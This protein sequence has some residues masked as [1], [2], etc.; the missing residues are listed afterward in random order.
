MNQTTRPTQFK[1]IP[2]VL[3]LAFDLGRKEWKL[4]FTVGRGERPRLRTVAAGDLGGLTQEIDRARQRWGVAPESRVVS[5]YEAGRDGFWLHRYLLSRGISN[6]VVDSSSIEVNRRAR[7][8]KT[9]RLDAQKLLRLL[10]RHDLGEEE[11]RVWSVV[12]VPSVEQEADRQLHRDWEELKQERTL[13][14]NRIQALLACQGITLR[15]GADFGDRLEGLALWDG[16]ALPLP[17]QERLKREWERLKL[18]EEQI[19]DLNREKEEAVASAADASLQQIQ[20]LTTL[21]GIGVTSAWLFV[22]E[23]FG[24]RQFRNRREVGALAGLA[25]VPCQSGSTDHEQGI[26]KAGNVRL[27]TM[28]IEI[29]WSWL[30][31]QPTSSL[32]LWFR[33]RYG[34]G[35]RRSRRVGIVALARKLLVSLWR[36]LETGV[37]PEGAQLKTA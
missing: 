17:L 27:R 34:P 29:A 35:S 32:S 14:R 10:V 20:Q 21:K 18:V 13:H 6:L 15:L 11:D 24:W 2:E 31:Y 37:V 7:R 22:R 16:S 19:R 23:F 3:Y 5:C 9:D 36:F 30:R 12:R 26:S 1:S 28:A 4:A 33:E 25:P 8:A